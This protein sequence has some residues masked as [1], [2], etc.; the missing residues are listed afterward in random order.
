MAARPPSDPKEL[1]KQMKEA[2]EHGIRI[3]PSV[4]AAMRVGVDAVA[5]IGEH[6]D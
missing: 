5:I 2:E 1:D 6:G 4:T 3:F